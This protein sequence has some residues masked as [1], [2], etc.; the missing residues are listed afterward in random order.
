LGTQ[1]IVLDT[2]LPISRDC[3]AGWAGVPA[4]VNT[5]LAYRVDDTCTVAITGNNLFD[6]TYRGNFYGE[7]RNFTVSFK[8]NF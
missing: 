8:S 7:P 1:K 6:K 5:Q 2:F 3:A 4:A